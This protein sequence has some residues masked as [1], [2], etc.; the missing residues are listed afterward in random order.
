[1]NVGLVSAIIAAVVALIGAILSF[2]ANRRALRADLEKVEM[3][4]ARKFTEK[5]Y[6]QR[7]ATYPIAFEITDDLRGKK[8][9]RAE[10]TREYLQQALER[11]IDWHRKNG[12]ILSQDT[13]VGYKQLR[14]ALETVIVREGALT[15]ELLVPIQKGKV[16]FRACMRKDL[17]L[18]YSE[19]R[20]ELE[21]SS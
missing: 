2:M 15:E 11:L 19:E 4:L 6:D 12:L 3:E 8:L 20:Q 13:V 9:F 10:I 1:M 18:L 16:Y 7:L 14:N 5:L 17:N 21:S